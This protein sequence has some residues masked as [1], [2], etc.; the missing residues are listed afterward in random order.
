MI[1]IANAPVSY[2][3]FEMTVG[4]I[5][6]LPSASSLLDAVAAAGYAGI[7]LGPPGCLGQAGELRDAL[8]AR[9][10]GLA[11][12]WIGMRFSDPDGFRQD[13]PLLDHTLDLF[14][15]ASLHAERP[16]RPKPTLGDAG[17]PARWENPGRGRDCPEIGLDDDGWRQLAASVTVA[18]ERCRER[19]FEATFHPHAGT[20]V[21]AKHEI[22][23]LL[24]LTEVGLCLDTGHLLLG[25]ADPVQAV[26][27]WRDRVNHVHLKDVRLIVLEAVIAERAGMEALWRRGAFCELGSGDVEI[28]AFLAALGDSGYSG[29]LVVEQDRYPRPGERFAD[30]VCAQARNRAFLSARGM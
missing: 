22:E 4:N 14:E 26:T 28:D 18:A 1:R 16:W 7:D 17:S 20:Y 21:E 11:G 23:R 27:D 29:W 13:L 10:L 6:D 19:G 5:R 8:Q 15:A 9:G 24:D 12:G 30:T 25:G 2:G 3:V